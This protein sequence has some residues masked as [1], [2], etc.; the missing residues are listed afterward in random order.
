MDA[1][2]V[3]LYVVTDPALTPAD[4]LVE[5]C[6]AAVRG[7][8]TL[9]QLRDKQ[10]SADELLPQT[11]ELR[12]ALRPL[13]VP[14]VVNDRIGVAEQAGVGVHLGVGDSDPV[15]AR[16]ALGDDP[17]VGWSVETSAQLGTERERAC[18]YLAA[19]PVWLTPTKPDAAAPLGPPGVAAIREAT[20]LPLVGIGG[21][22]TPERAA[23][24][25]DA[26]ADGVAVVSGVFGA[27]D[28]E[29]AAAELRAAVDE[30]LAR[31]RP[32]ALHVR[33]REP[34]VEEQHGTVSSR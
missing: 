22:N 24:V 11:I 15:R 31:K 2:D 3:R 30:A 12:D 32:P 7:G 4:R 5:M 17:I 10:A 8:A 16:D 28:P 26:G 13:G 21:I 1:L 9:V 29:S 19:S 23:A 20:A 33:Q 34:G 14:L 6:L 25:I 27:G 18:S